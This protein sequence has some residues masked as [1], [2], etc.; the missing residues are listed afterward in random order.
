MHPK[1]I[2]FPTDAKL[3]TKARENLVALAKE[4]GVYLAPALL[5]SGLVALIK[6][7]RY[8]HAKQHNRAR[9]E[10]KRIR[11]YLGR[12]TRNIRRKIA[13][14][15][16]LVDVF[17]RPLWLAERLAPQAKRD[18]NPKAYFPCTHPNWSASTKARPTSR[19]HL[20]LRLPTTSWCIPPLQTQPKFLSFLR[21]HCSISRC[22]RWII[23]GK[24]PLRLI[25][26]NG[27]VVIRSDMSL[28]HLQLLAAFQT[29]QEFCRN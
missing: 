10:L 16:A 17:R 2:A 28:Q 5:Q 1:A 23:I 22:C 20:G 6:Q 8:A 25:S 24:I 3:M 13:G 26:L 29:D 11:T 4:W 19:S 12:M 15:A 14:N 9:R 21:P 7:G 18:H 27:Q